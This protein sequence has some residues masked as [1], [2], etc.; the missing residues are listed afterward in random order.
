MSKIDKESL[1]MTHLSS[2]E[3]LKNKQRH[4]F[5]SVGITTAIGDDGPYKIKTRTNANTQTGGTKWANH[6]PNPD[7]CRQTPP[8]PDS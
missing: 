8:A 3:G 6:R 4:G 2:S 5:F 7:R 1:R